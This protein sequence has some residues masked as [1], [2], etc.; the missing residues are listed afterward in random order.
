ML[1]RTRPSAQ[2]RV[3]L[4]LAALAG[5]LQCRIGRRACSRWL[6][7]LLRGKL[8]EEL[9]HGLTVATLLLLGR[10]RRR[11]LPRQATAAKQ[12]LQQVLHARGRRPSGRRRWRSGR[13]LRLLL[14]LRHQ[15]RANHVLQLLQQLQ[16]RNHLL[17][18]HRRRS[19]M[20][21]HSCL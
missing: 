18:I 10:R 7:L 3:Y 1:Q 11:L 2:Q 16:R 9:Q 6:L 4:L 14:H 12:V 5:A 21:L 19:A 8:L 15:Q 20:P 17:H 13:L